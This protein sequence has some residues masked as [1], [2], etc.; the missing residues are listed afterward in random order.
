MLRVA[1]DPKS[2]VKIEV[3]R[4]SLNQQLEAQILPNAI[5]SRPLK[6]SKTFASLTAKYSGAN[7]R[8]K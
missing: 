6:E 7:D 3:W 2:A 1:R 8:K 5:F 4:I